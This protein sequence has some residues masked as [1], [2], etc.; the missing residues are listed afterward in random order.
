LLRSLNRIF[1]IP[2]TVIQEELEALYDA[3]CEDLEQCANQ[4]Q[5]KQRQQQ[6]Y[7]SSTLDY[8]N[9][10]GEYEDDDEEDD[11]E[12]D[13]EEEEYDGSS[14]GSETRREIF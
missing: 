14:H 13:E 2:R 10:N 1:S 9:E 8:R 12:C 7:P 4:Q 5:Q 3:Y 11:N 6:Q